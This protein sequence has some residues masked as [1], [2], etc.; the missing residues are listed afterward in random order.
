MGGAEGC[1]WTT[2]IWLVWLSWTQTKKKNQEWHFQT[3]PIPKHRGTASLVWNWNITF[4]GKVCISGSVCSLAGIHRH[5]PSGSVAVSSLTWWVKPRF[6]QNLIA[7]FSS[8]ELRNHF[9]VRYWSLGLWSLGTDQEIQ[10][11]YQITTGLSFL[12]RKTKVSIYRT[13]KLLPEHLQI[14]LTTILL[15]ILQVKL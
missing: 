2:R 4:L 14:I 7:E 8:K 13:I 11:M 10:G 1:L 3:A 12:F 9:Q 6:G 15:K 5:V